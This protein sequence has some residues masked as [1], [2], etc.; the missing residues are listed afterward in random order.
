MLLFHDRY[1]S[2]WG[3]LGNEYFSHASGA[4]YALSS[5]VVGALATAKNDRLIVY[6][7]FPYSESSRRI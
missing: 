5:Q 6:L 2:S 1:E 3:L 4:L 7:F